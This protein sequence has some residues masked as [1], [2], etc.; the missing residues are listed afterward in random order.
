MKNYYE[1]DQKLFQ[2]VANLI[3]GDMDSYYVVYDLSVKYIYKIIYDIVKDYH[4]TEDLVQET[5]LTVY[6]KINTLQDATKFYAWA[7]RVATNLTLRYIQKNN[8]E[9]LML[10]SEDGASEFAF[11]V[12][13]Q[14]NEAF[15]PENV[16]MDAE[17]QRII[18]EI[19]DGLSV[20][21]KITVQ[22]FYY[23]EMSVTEIAET[24]GCSRGTVMSRLNYARKAIKA[25]VVD[26]AENKNTRLYSLAELPL[27]Y[28]I[29]KRAVEE[30][31][32]AE[33]AVAETTMVGTAMAVT[34]ASVGEGMSS[35]GSVVATNLG[36]GMLAKVG[37]SLGIKLAVGV[38]AA[39][40]I[41]AGGLALRNA[42]KDDK[43]NDNVT[44][45]VIS[46]ERDVSD[47]E[48]IVTDTT[49]VEKE[50][51]ELDEDE[52]YVDYP[53]SLDSNDLE[54]SGKQVYIKRPPLLSFYPDGKHVLHGTNAEAYNNTASYFVT[55]FSMNTN[56]VVS[57][58]MVS[59]DM[60]S[61][62][63]YI[64]HYI[65]GEVSGFGFEV[66]E[67]EKWDN[68]ISAYKVDM[69]YDSGD[70]TTFYA[71]YYPVDEFN[72]I[73]IHID[74][75]VGTLN[76]YEDL[77]AEQEEILNFYRTEEKLFIVVDPE[78]TEVVK[79]DAAPD[80]S[81]TIEDADDAG[82]NSHYMKVVEDFYLYQT[83]PFGN[84]YEH[85]ERQGWAEIYDYAI[86]DMDGDGIEELIIRYGSY[87]KIYEY[88]SINMQ[89][90][91]EYGWTAEVTTVEAIKF[92]ENGYYL[93]NYD[94]IGISKW[95]AVSG[96]SEFIW[97]CN[98]NWSISWYQSPYGEDCETE[99]EYL[100]LY[101]KDGDG[102]IYYEEIVDENYVVSDV[103]FYDN[104]ELEAKIS[105]YTEGSKPIDIQ[106]IDISTV[107]NQ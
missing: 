59:Y 2:A 87:I 107:V 19:V 66:G 43:T 72:A 8:R 99:S 15:I 74:G 54:H 34:E 61:D 30:F 41:V 10:D 103:I 82:Y 79:V 33:A 89:I 58:A 62:Y 44:T 14:D 28:I 68:G 1:E 5:Y 60:D 46:T 96:G 91:E 24:M 93:Y 106:F 92:Y 75:F 97:D 73:L 13:T 32:F 20:E 51:L 76:S 27:F 81:N 100:A 42:L 88:D 37:T 77:S 90:K 16:V 55:N 23:E 39:G 71:L 65:E 35:A 11:E 47:T 102:T 98:D 25:A 36:K 6:N 78:T 104:A 21:Q 86:C 105:E 49:V 38:A 22:Y 69:I 50:I 53:I 83:D 64:N 56:N 63:S 95:D 57:M 70:K 101:D 84:Y 67:P 52:Y 3:A 94:G 18:A 80:V 12:A 26:L 4:T 45:E 31:L 40:L 85:Q 48:V 17:K 29:F 9:L 7:G